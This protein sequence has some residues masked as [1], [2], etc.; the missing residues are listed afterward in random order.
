MNIE[1]LSFRQNTLNNDN[2]FVKSKKEK[3]NNDNGQQDANE[4]NPNLFKFESSLSKKRSIFIE[5]SDESNSSDEELDNIEFHDEIFEAMEK[6]TNSKD[7]VDI[8]NSHDP[9]AASQIAKLVHIHALENELSLSTNRYLQI[10]TSISPKT[11][12]SVI[13]WLIPMNHYFQFPQ[14]TLFLSITYF[15]LYLQRK[16]IEFSLVK[17]LAVCC[18][19]LAAKIDTHKPPTPNQIYEASNELFPPET[20]LQMEMQILNVLGFELNFPIIPLFLNRYLSAADASQD[21]KNVSFKLAELVIQKFDFMNYKASQ[22]SCACAFLT[23]AAYSNTNGAKQA[24]LISCFDD[25]P[26]FIELCQK[27]QKVAIDEKEKLLSEEN[28]NTFSSF[29]FERDFQSLCL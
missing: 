14:E 2:K 29:N 8:R 7:W 5:E 25:V 16:E 3:L 20:L 23:C 6:N 28:I 10:Q 9:K 24:A 12:D 15:D 26:L 21:E 27:I 19:R 18:F 1:N 4:K 13:R 11:R 22:I 17:L